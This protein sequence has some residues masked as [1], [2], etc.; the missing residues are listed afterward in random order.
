M[1]AGGMQELASLRSLNEEGR[2]S[3]DPERDISI[4]LPA[5]R[6]EREEPALPGTDIPRAG[7]L[8]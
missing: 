8:A 2:E 1:V 5:R 7:A 6:S 3:K 4:P